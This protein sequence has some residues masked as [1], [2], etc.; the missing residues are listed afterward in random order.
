MAIITHFIAF[1]AGAC[2]GFVL[3]AVIIAG[4]RDERE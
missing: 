3:A 4:G 1:S 2:F